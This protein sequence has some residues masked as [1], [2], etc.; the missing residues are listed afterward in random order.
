MLLFCVSEIIYLTP[1]CVATDHVLVI[2]AILKR[3]F[4]VFGIAVQLERQ[5]VLMSA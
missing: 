4:L 2:I 5:F 1:C 3:N